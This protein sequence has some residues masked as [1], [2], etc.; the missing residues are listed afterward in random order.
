MDKEKFFGQMRKLEAAYRTQPCS[1]ATLN[2]YWDKLKGFSDEW[3]ET[4]INKLV[5][6]ERF[7]PPIASFLQCQ[8]LERKTCPNCGSKDWTSWVDD[9]CGKCYWKEYR[10]NVVKKKQGRS[11]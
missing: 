5:T 7:F 4:V 9:R 2:I 10:A 1:G 6:T 11:L 3:L 8:G